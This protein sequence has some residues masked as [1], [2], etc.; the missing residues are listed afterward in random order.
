[1]SHGP[2]EPLKRPLR[3][4]HVTVSDTGGAGVACMRLHRALGSIGI[5]SRVLVRWRSS[6][7]PGV[8]SVGPR[9]HA[10]WRTRLDGFPL[11]FFSRRKIFAWWSVNW[12]RKG[13]PARIGDWEPDVIHAHWIGAGFVPIPWF[14][15]TGRPVV[16]TIHDMWPFTGGCHYSADCDRYQR[17][18]GACPQLG[19]SKQKDLSFRANKNKFR[20]WNKFP[21]ALVSPS[22]WLADVA[23]QSFV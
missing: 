4:M 14:A 8:T 10:A 3:V 12:L 6:E 2:P 13:P 20:H 19:S 21:G 23:R 5:E 9:W 17:G 1:M 18:C 15:Q 22:V 7:D 16:W 11:R